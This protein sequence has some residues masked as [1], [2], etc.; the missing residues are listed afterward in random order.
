MTSFL[1][2]LRMLFAVLFNRPLDVRLPR[3]FGGATLFPR[4]GLV[5]PVMAGGSEKEEDGDE[6]EEGKETDDAGGGADA[7]DDSDDAEA[8]D[9][10]EGEPGDELK[11]WKNQ[12]RKHERRAKTE[13][14]KR[15]EAEGKLKKRE[16]ADKSERDKAIDKAREE[17]RTAALTEAEKERRSD[18]LEVAVTRLANKVIEIGEGDDAKKVRFADSDDALLYIE[19]AISKGDID[20]DDIFDDDNRVKSDALQGELAELLE[21]KPHYQAK[22]ESAAADAGKK[23]GKSA[24]G[25]ADQGKGEGAGSKELEEM[26]AEDHLKRI[27]RNK[28]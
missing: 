8:D 11:T 12:S 26:S 4:E 15:E 21:S 18:R 28:E 19:R 7:E 1:A 17:G 16:E 27:K 14:K 23:K 10:D 20:A 13:R 24:N 5:L 3:P 22:S 2:H 25:S 6:N 9:G